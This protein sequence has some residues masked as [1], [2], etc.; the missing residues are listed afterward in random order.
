MLGRLTHNGPQR[1]LLSRRRLAGRTAL[2]ASAWVVTA[3]L[4]AAPL[5]AAKKTYDYDEDPVRLAEEALEAGRLLEAAP[6]FQ[7]GIESEWKLDRA[8]LGL[9]EVL[10]REDKNTEA[11]PLYRRALEEHRRIRN[12]ATYPEASAGLGLVLLDL[13][14]TEEARAELE[15]ALRDEKNSWNANYG[16]A[17]IL[18]GQHRFQEAL[19]YLD[20][21]KGLKGV[22]KGLDQYHYGMALV[23]VGLGDVASAEKNA[24]L[25]LTLNPAEAE[26]GTL[27]AQIYTARGARTLAIDAYERALATPG[28]IATPKVYYDLGVLYEAEKLF[29]DA[30]QRYLRAIEIDSTFAP[31]YKNS[32]RLYALGNQADR[33]GRFYLR[34]SN[35][36]PEDAEGW[37]GQAEAFISLGLNKPALE[38]AEKAYSLDSTSANVRLSLARATYLSNDLDRSDRL[39]KTVSDTTLFEA[40]DWINRGQIAMA[41]KGFDRADELLTRAIDME[42]ENAEAYAAKGKLFLSR[43]RPDSAVVYYQKSLDLNRKSLVAKINLAVAYLQLRKASDAAATLRE[44]IAENP[45]WAPAHNYLGQAMVMADSLSTA[46]AEYRKAMELDPT[47]AAAMRGAGFVHLKRQ[48]Y[49]QAEAVLLKATAADPRVADGWASLGS[50]QAGLRK[51]D[52]GIKSFEKALE[53]SPNHEGALRG[54]EALKKARP[55]ASGR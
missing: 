18:I 50:A 54:L 20:K 10:R 41:Q 39:Y 16:M 15:S 35:L 23:Q 47:N 32:A 37:F 29:N 46:L 40:G 7:E 26:Y 21:G 36:V 11:E 9:A 14:R 43:Q 48:D 30:V 4:L 42:P 51:I 22:A 8:C 34:Y 27:V 19:P 17:R 2:A 24:M 25:A 44:V 5:Q 28:V 6:L 55:A 31:A 38:A 49:A 52:E 13:G 1:G 33:A 3:L 53:I 45:K 12:G